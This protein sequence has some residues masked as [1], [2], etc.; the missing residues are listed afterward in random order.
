MKNSMKQLFRTPVKTALFLLLITAAALLLVFSAGLLSETDQRIDKVENSF[1]TVA[2]VEQVPAL[3]GITAQ[4]INPCFGLG[5]QSRDVWD[6]RV[7]VENLQF[8]GANYVTAPEYRPYYITEHSDW[9]HTV[10]VDRFQDNW[11]HIFEFTAL[12]DSDEL[13]GAYVRVD[14]FLLRQHTDAEDMGV[15]PPQEGETVF[16]CQCG[17][18]YHIQ[19]GIITPIKK[20]KRY[21]ATVELQH[22]CQYHTIPNEISED[23]WT[24][25]LEYVIHDAPY[26]SQCDANG[27]EI[28]SEHFPYLENGSQN[29][30]RIEEVTEDFY[31]EGGRGRDWLL[32]AKT[33]NQHQKYFPVMP[34]SGLQMIPV[35]QENR[36][37]LSD[38]REITREEYD[39]GASVCLVPEDTLQKNGWKIGD[40]LSLPMLCSLYGPNAAMTTIPPRGDRELYLNVRYD[41]SPIKADGSVY[42]PF[43]TAEYEIVGTYGLLQNNAVFTDGEIY[44]D[45]ILIPEN[46]VRASDADNIACYKHLDGKTATFQIENGTIDDFDAALRANVP[47]AENLSVT[48]NDNGYTEIMESLQSTRAAAQLLFIVGLLAAVAVVL[49][50]LYFFIVKEKKR[51]A[52]ERSLG[53]SKRQCRVS[54]MAGI[55]ILTVLAS[56]LGTAGAA[57][58]LE[59]F[60]RQEQTASETVREENFDEENPA[61]EIAEADTV[62]KDAATDVLLDP[63]EYNPK[64]SPWAQNASASQNITFD[65]RTPVFVYAVIPLALILLVFALSLLLVN[66]NLKVEPIYLLSGKME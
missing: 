9:E 56:S 23:Y 12:E 25:N 44:P 55:L 41:F 24:T 42:E 36:A 48:Y 39:S 6:K 21:I 29:I 33:V 2:R 7:S 10:E 66:R 20:G 63:G 27:D 4:W 8:E 38:G 62:E 22:S 26:S 61:E 46:S 14:R 59:V 17:G 1:T 28:K 15:F 52:I 5:V 11:L 43:W 65:V 35:F 18:T 57:M 51:T 50:L 16:L 60:H 40:K 37:Y 32:W 30:C 64:Y 47:Q 13:G 31:E 53:M 34:V 3:A 54:L 19:E 58:A 49:L 45:T